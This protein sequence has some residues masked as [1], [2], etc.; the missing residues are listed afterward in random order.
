[1]QVGT[2]FL[3]LL[4]VYLLYSLPM[5]YIKHSRVDYVNTGELKCAALP[6]LLV[7]GLVSRVMRLHTAPHRR[8]QCSPD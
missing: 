7:F 2:Y 4:A 6:R 1:M 3:V 5:S 8:R